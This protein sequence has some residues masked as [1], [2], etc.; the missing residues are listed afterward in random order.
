MK[1]ILP[2]DGATKEYQTSHSVPVSQEGSI[3]DSVEDSKVPDV[4]IVHVPSVL[5]VKASAAAQSSLAG[6]A[7]GVPI[8]ISNTDVC[9]PV[10]VHE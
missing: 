3:E 4:V 6:G 1:S 7:G 2:E 5:T 9:P 10:D 8:Q